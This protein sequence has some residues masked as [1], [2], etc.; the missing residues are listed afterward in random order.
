MNILPIRPM[1][2]LRAI[3]VAALALLAAAPVCAGAQSHGIAM[4]GEPA[5]P[6]GFAQLPYV[7][8]S[9]AKGGRLRL[10]VLGAFDSL[11]PFN[12][13]SGS[14]ADGLQGN[15]FQ[16]LMARN[17]DEPFSLYGLVAKSIET[18]AERT[19]VTFRLDAR[20][21][22]ADG[23]PV[24]PEDVLFTFHLLRERGRP[25]YRLAYAMV[26]AAQAVDEDGVRFDLAGANDRELPLILALMPVFSRHRV[27]AATFA[28]PNLEI[29]VGSGPY[30]ITV[31]E[32]GARLIL[33]RNW[34]YWGSDL[35]VQRGLYNFDE[36]QIEYF[37]DP[38]SMF[39][40]FRAGRIDFRMETNPS[41]WRSGY[42]FPAAR[43]GR[44]RIASEK[45]AAP[46]GMEGFAFN[47][48]RAIFA[49]VRVREALAMLFDFEWLNAHVFGGLYSRTQSFFEASD[50][51]SNG[52]PASEAERALLAAW[53]DA[54]RADILEGAWAPPHSDGSGRDRAMLR[55]ALA[56]LGQAGYVLDNGRL[57]QASSGAA[58][59]FEI[60]TGDRAQERLA[61]YFSAALA[62]VGVEARVR[63]VDEAQYQRRRQTFDFDMMP[64]VWAA[65]ASPGNE[66][67]SRWS[68]ASATE[69][70]S[71]NLAGAR[72]PAVDG[73]I[74]ALL[75][76]RTRDAFVTATRA[77]DRALLS[78]FY[79]VPLFH[80]GEQRF[81]WWSDLAKPER[82]ARYATP[83][84]GTTL[85]AWWRASP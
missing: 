45:S 80:S 84:Y 5:L 12:V 37:R 24:T 23:Q 38:T 6:S 46:Q 22:F 76:A 8:A 17:F 13:Y 74:D 34:N 49:D 43:D 69:P 41:R 4:H 1:L 20:A 14:A 11:N 33:K 25:Q 27:K 44:V 83:I 77:Y 55:R 15:V 16:S 73:L 31:V 82:A 35:P 64:S 71:Y 60:L 40:A 51:S 62:R 21:R 52:A 78:G 7:N 9:A 39:E 29:P 30:Q 53:P 48:R 47:T 66:Q 50:L 75:A 68:S 2:P 57:R 10:G 32:P 42:Q 58:L 72:S 70:A 67:R 18:D 61:L 3:C 26:V 56:L 59:R 19:Y 85:E 63:L 81:A 36:I 28:A 54:V 79:I 65:S